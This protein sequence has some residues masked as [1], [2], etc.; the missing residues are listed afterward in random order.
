MCVICAR[1]HTYIFVCF[2][3]GLPSGILRD[4]V[5]SL[6]EFLFF[7]IAAYASNLTRLN[8]ILKTVLPELP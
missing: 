1:T 7:S 2:T 8:L 6:R 5:T 3:A 4:L